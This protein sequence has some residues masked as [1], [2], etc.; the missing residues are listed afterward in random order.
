MNDEHGSD[1][2]ASVTDH[3]VTGT[4][5]ATVRFSDAA[6]DASKLG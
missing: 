6:F 2:S 5:F 3:C 1:G 4:S